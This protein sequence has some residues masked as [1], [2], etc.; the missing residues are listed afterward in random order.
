MNSEFIT[1][2]KKELERPEPIKKVFNKELSQRLAY[3]RLA[4]GIR[5]VRDLLGSL[6]FLE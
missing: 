6:R 2:S 1:M 5:Q 3:E 4:I